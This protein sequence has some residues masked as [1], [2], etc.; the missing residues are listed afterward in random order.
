MT[1]DPGDIVLDPTCGSGTTAYVAEQW[2]R[3]WITMDTSRVALTLARARLMAA[4]FPAYTLKTDRVADGFRYKTV[5]HITLKSIANN[6]KI[7]A[8]HAQ[9]QPH[10]DA[11]L[12]QI[13]AVS[14]KPYQ[15]WEVPRPAEDGQGE[16]HEL[17]GEWWR[18]RRER[19]DAIDAAIRENPDMETLYDQPEVRKDVVRVTGPFTVESLQP[20]RAENGKRKNKKSDGGRFLLDMIEQLRIAGVTTSR[21]GERLTFERLDTYPGKYVQAVGTYTQAG[22][23][24]RAAVLI[25][26][27]YGTVSR[28]MIRNAAKEAV[29][30]REIDFDILIACGFAFDPAVSEETRSNMGRLVV[31]TARIAPDLLLMGKDLKKDGR[32][33]LF[34]VFGEPDVRVEQV[35]GRMVVRLLGMDVY[36][37]K[38]HEIRASSTDEIACWFIDTNYNEE[39]FFVRHAYFTGADNPYEKLQ[40]ALRAEIDEAAWEL[41][42]RTESIPFDPPATGKIAVKVINHFGDEVIKVVEVS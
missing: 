10:L 3:R 12:A 42:R 13:N 23:T 38:E 29:K 9:F 31:Q 20:H 17:L 37:P 14:P 11:L 26:P 21:A 16:L 8:L 7:D 27:Q 24:G 41:L 6:E 15:E 4:R 2:G 28:D 33:N 36:D 19:Q 32:G 1:T 25:G 22:Q 5:P 34:T 30:D 18:V 35:D 40:K 39:S